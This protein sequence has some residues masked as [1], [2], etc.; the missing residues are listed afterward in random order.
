[1]AR[2]RGLVALLVVGTAAVVWWLW[3]LYRAPNRGELSGYWQ[4]VVAIPSLAAAVVTL[5]R[6]G[7]A[8]T[9]PDADSGAALDWLA[10]RL[11]DAVERQWTQ[12][13]VA[14]RLVAPEPI[15]VRWARPGV[16]VAGPAEA[17]AASTHF[18]P[19][20][21]L[22]AVRAEGLRSGGVRELH[23]LYGGVGSGRLVIVGAPGAG[24]SGAAVLLLLDA[25][26]HRHGV[27]DGERAGV[28]VPVLFTLREWSPRT[29]PMRAWLIDQLRAS[30]G[31]LFAGGG[32]AS[33]AGQLIDQGRIALIV[34]G[35]DEISEEF[36]PLVL[37]ALSEQAT[38]RL[39]LLARGEEMAQVA[40]RELL[41]GA[42]AVELQDVGP[43]AASDYLSRVQRDPPP[44]RWHELIELLR[45]APNGPLA[46]ALRTPLILTLVRDTFRAGD[47]IGELLDHCASLGPDLSRDAVE[48]YL[49]DR[50]LPG[51]YTPGPGQ[52][53]PPFA[54]PAARRALGLVAVRMNRAH[55]RD[56]AWWHIPSWTSALPRVLAVGAAVGLFVGLGLLLLPEQD[57]PGDRVAAAIVLAA[58]AGGMLGTWL[59]GRR[60]TRVPATP[61]RHP[62][63]HP[64][65]LFL[66]GLVFGT[67]VSHG[68]SA[69]TAAT[70]TELF[71][72]LVIALGYAGVCYLGLS[73]LVK[74]SV[75]RYRKRHH[76]AVP[77]PWHLI[78]RSQMFSFVPGLVGSMAASLPT[79]AGL[80]LLLF[81]VALMGLVFGSSL[82]RAARV[83]V[84]VLTPVGL[85]RQSQGSFMVVIWPL[86]G[87][88][89]GS[90]LLRW[91]ETGIWNM[92]DTDPSLVLVVL[93]R[94][95]LVLLVGLVLG[96]CYPTRWIISMASLQLAVRH[97]TPLHLVRFLDDAHQRGV[98]RTVGQFYQFRHARLQDRLG[99]RARAVR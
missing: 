78:R 4:L 14:R 54:L 20:P 89:A 72:E 83:S 53:E 40:E 63:G 79:G 47:D 88:Y 13:A 26:R 36:R 49:L 76:G 22:T 38:F 19:L 58:A 10:D 45:S 59:V 69:S 91:L 35:L 24:K 51:A 41:E 27:S 28:P 68:Y 25:M 95:G 93:T 74:R 90:S 99:G 71:T 81:L 48:D 97:R 86:L 5:V 57:A 84:T 77:V 87:I 29:Q 60:L 9:G 16:S 64:A 46:R 15:A 33:D 39:V 42:V 73:F 80:V 44:H 55:T 7:Q 70:G 43:A 65:A 85:W 66:L 23:R 94:L 50:V 1:M 18:R 12:T 92:L 6:D 67:L 37:R 17:A 52:P 75:L 3:E 11:A 98:L 61:R 32:G 62:L 34:D 56:L 8:R 21:G 31:G 82:S 2:R 96:F 30:Y